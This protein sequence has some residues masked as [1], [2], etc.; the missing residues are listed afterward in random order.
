M[1]DIN[2]WVAIN[3]DDTLDGRWFE[4]ED[5]AFVHWAEYGDSYEYYWVP[6][7]T[8]MNDEFEE[9]HTTHGISAAQLRAHERSYRRPA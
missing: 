2:R 4:S 5:E 1:P 3:P 8:K 7:A 9:L 6:R